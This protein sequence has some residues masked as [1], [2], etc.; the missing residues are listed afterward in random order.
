MR[1]CFNFNVLSRELGFDPEREFSTFLPARRHRLSSLLFYN[2]PPSWKAWDMKYTSV[3]S[4]WPL[5][6]LLGSSSRNP[7]LREK[8]VHLL[9]TLSPTLILGHLSLTGMTSPR[10]I[11]AF[12]NHLGNMRLE[13]NCSFQRWLSE[14]GDKIPQ[15][16]KA[17][18]HDG[19]QRLPNEILLQKFFKRVLDQG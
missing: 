1:S 19:M 14:K 17:V 18:F 7:L 2:Q 16:H 11:W 13:Q 9:G 10:I 6:G 8:P 5:S 12:R 4:C 15:T 3:T